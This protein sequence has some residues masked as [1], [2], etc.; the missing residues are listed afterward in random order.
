VVARL[1][2]DVAAAKRS[3]D[4]RDSTRSGSRRTSERNRFRARWCE[5]D[6]TR[7]DSVGIRTIVPQADRPIILSDNRFG[8]RSTDRRRE[9][10]RTYPYRAREV[11]R[12][13]GRNWCIAADT[14]VPKECPDGLT[15][16]P[17]WGN[18]WDPGAWMLFRCA[19]R[20]T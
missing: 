3:R 7:P 4:S 11:G 14:L 17:S 2:L 18:C 1:M 20:R 8:H 19:L 9:A 5:L 10:K 15:S 12:L 16:L 13:C 6:R